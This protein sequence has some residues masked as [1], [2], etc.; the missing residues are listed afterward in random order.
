MVILRTIE[1]AYKDIKDKDENTSISKNFIRRLV[2]QG[3]IPT[4][5]SGN[6]YLINMP[7]LEEYLN[8][9]C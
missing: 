8:N 2:I 1:A 5:R 7:Q 9:L 3:D 6:K 4:I